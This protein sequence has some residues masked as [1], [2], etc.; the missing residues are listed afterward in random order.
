MQLL[1]RVISSPFQYFRFAIFGVFVLTANAPIAL[2]IPVLSLDLD[3]TIDGI[4]SS[5]SVSAGERFDVDIVISEVEFPDSIT[6]FELRLRS[7]ETVL[8]AIATNAGGFLPDPTID[9]AL[10]DEPGVELASLSLQPVGSTGEGV[11]GTVTFAA[12]GPGLSTPLTL[13]DVILTAPFGVPVP[14]VLEP[15]LVSV[16]AIPEPG[17]ALL[18][19]AGLCSVVLSGRGAR[20]R[21]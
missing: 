13:E 19:G 20:K 15:G 8:R 14:F 10:P 3:T 2:A 5:R 12:I 9:L 11:L 18:F 21:K 6:G 16:A 7:D 4:Q 17:A 1:N